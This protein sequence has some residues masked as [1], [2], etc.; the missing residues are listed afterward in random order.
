MNS[1][2]RNIKDD[3][4]SG[5][6]AGCMGTYIRPGENCIQRM[7]A[8]LEEKAERDRLFSETN[9]LIH[10]DGKTYPWN[11]LNEDFEFADKMSNQ[12]LCRMFGLWDG[13]IRGNL[14]FK[15]LWWILDGKE[16][17]YG[18][19]SDDDLL[20][21]MERLS[22]GEIFEGLWESWNYNSTRSQ[23][24]YSKVP[25]VQDVAV[26]ITSEKIASRRISLGEKIS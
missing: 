14:R 1:R 15:N 12:G 9:S 11:H 7:G 25:G 23:R 16:F 8:T 3:K 6:P 17:G 5:L 19:L 2:V 18:D 21:I 20:H 22:P 4:L 26:T 24:D 13:Q 10:W